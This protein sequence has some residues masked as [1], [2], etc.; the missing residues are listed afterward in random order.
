[1]HQPKTDGCHRRRSRQRPF[2]IDHPLTA[3]RRLSRSRG[4]AR[5][6]RPALGLRLPEVLLVAQPF[7]L[8]SGCGKGV[9]ELAIE[10]INCYIE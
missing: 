9:R 2:A 5:S 1:M 6:Y 8:P 7:N 3:A 4:I 10:K